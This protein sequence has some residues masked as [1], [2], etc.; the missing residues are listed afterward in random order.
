MF[1]NSNYL[2]AFTIFL[3]SCLAQSVSIIDAL[4]KEGSVSIIT[5]ILEKRFKSVSFDPNNVPYTLFAPTDEAIRNAGAENLPENLLFSILDYHLL[6]EV[7][8]SKNITNYIQLYP[9]M[10]RDIKYVNLPGGGPQVLGLFSSGSNVIVK[11]G[12][13][14]PSEA[15]V[16]VTKA[17]ILAAKGVIHIVDKVLKIPPRI[18]TI[19]EGSQIFTV[20]GKELNASNLL[21]LIDCEPGITLFAPSNTAFTELLKTN[22]DPTPSSLIPVF[23]NHVISGQV[24]YSTKFT[25]SK[26]YDTLLSG[27]KVLVSR[28]GTGSP[29]IQNQ[30]LIAQDLLAENGVI[31]GI[32]FIIVPDKNIYT[33]REKPADSPK[34]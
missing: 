34:K 2:F 3:G 16:H 31:Q 27:S 19:L 5:S 30:P 22:I 6:N 21:P 17:D 13:F 25:E 20:L 29:L 1:L 10:Q 8:L 33:P 26:Y 14:D 24:L 11:D 18:S 32:N 9:T 28:S 12:I 7:V 15:P 23:K 4:K